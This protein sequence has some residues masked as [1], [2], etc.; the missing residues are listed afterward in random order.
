MSDIAEGGS[1]AGVEGRL[2]EATNPDASVAEASRSRRGRVLGLGALVVGVLGAA[3]WFVG[4]SPLPE[5]CFVD[6]TETPCDA[7]PEMAVLPPSDVAPEAAVEVPPPH[8]PEPLVEERCF[9]P[10]PEVEIPCDQSFDPE[11]FGEEKCFLIGG[12]EIPCPSAD[13]LGLLGK[14]FTIEDPPV[15]I[16]CPS[17]GVVPNPYLIGQDITAS[18]FPTARLA[19][20]RATYDQIVGSVFAVGPVLRSGTSD[21]SSASGTAW[22]VHPRFAI[23]NQHVIEGIESIPLAVRSSGD[24]RV[25]LYRY[26]DKRP[27]NGR[28]IAVDANQDVAIIELL[29]SVDVVPLVVSDRPAAVGEPV[30]YVGHPSRMERTWISGL[31][32]VTGY[33]APLSAASVTSTVPGHPGASGSPIVNLGGEVVSL[34][35]GGSFN[36]CPYLEAQECIADSSV[37]YASLPVGPTATRGIDGPALRKFFTDATGVSLPPTGA[38]GSAVERVLVEAGSV[39]SFAA[40]REREQASERGRATTVSNFP[41]S[42]RRTVAA[43]Y[44]R[45]ADAVFLV[46]T[47]E[48]GPIGTAWL[49]GPTTVVTNE[50]VSTPARSGDVVRLRRRDGSVIQA[51]VVQ[52]SV[53][54]DLAILRLDAALDT[55]PLRIAR[56]NAGV[57]VPVF[58]IG[59]PNW[60]EQLWVTGLGVTTGYDTRHR[61]RML[62]TVPSESGASG[63]PILNLDGEVIA[64]LSFVTSGP[65]LSG[66]YPVADR[67]VQYSSIPVRPGAGGVD[68]S[69]LRS[70]IERHAGTP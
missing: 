29:Q 28:V 31:G 21:A 12:E 58:Y 10:P 50:H 60:M 2:G 40:Y 18:G 13:D 20:A 39:G 44:D 5:R 53:A 9:T 4:P 34:L 11:R 61:N 51:R 52:Q 65:I 23:T 38:R 55:P 16:P 27:M 25:S 24:T 62:T 67:S 69:T 22:I 30:M 26:P 1:A 56:Q 70:Y 68:A 48:G 3:V 42:H 43:L 37:Q 64:I 54:D 66:G 49:A 33:Q 15:E 14:C 35:T 19:D 57:D 47:A 45:L 46:E 7:V 63:S 17:A 36:N 41:V 8:E 59:H 32:V 6:G